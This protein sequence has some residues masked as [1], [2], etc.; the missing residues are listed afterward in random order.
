[1]ERLGF[2]AYTSSACI[3][4]KVG[5]FLESTLYITGSYSIV[6]KSAELFIGFSP[7]FV[8][9]GALPMINYILFI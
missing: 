7:E 1:L 4:L 2:Y 8:V 6:L 9:A 5:I 3:F